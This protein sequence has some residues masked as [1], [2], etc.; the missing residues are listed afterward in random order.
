[1]NISI[2]KLPHVNGLMLH[3]MTFL[4]TV[5][6]DLESHRFYDEYNFVIIFMTVFCLS[7]Q[8]FF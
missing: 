1:M 2:T 4:G 8:K 6:D 5:Y 7:S 3:F